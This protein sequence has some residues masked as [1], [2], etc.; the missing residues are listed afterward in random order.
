MIIINASFQLERAFYLMDS[1]MMPNLRVKRQHH[2]QAIKKD[3]R[4]SNNVKSLDA[5]KISCPLNEFSIGSIST[6]TRNRVESCKQALGIMESSR[7]S[8]RK[9]SDQFIAC[10][11]LSLFLVFVVVQEEFRRLYW[12]R[13][14]D[15]GGRVFEALFALFWNWR[16]NGR[17]FY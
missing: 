13:R 1:S 3:C 10:L 11:Q 17:T 14:F 5:D 7:S 9:H 15:S 16:K 12:L 2:L 6:R 4:R 8:W